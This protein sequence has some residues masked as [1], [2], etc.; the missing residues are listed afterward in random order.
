M[1]SDMKTTQNSVVMG[2]ENDRKEPGRTTPGMSRRGFL[3]KGGA[4]AVSLAPG[5][6]TFAGEVKVSTPSAE[7]LGW[8]AS[9]QHFTYRRFG[10]FEALDKVAA[11][12]LRHIEI[13]SN[14]NLD[15]KRPGLPAHEDMPAEVR[16]ELKARLAERVMSIPSVFA[17]F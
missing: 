2:E 13:R 16:K 5:L 12:G 7:K 8:R 6:S 3:A 15:G 17:D 1:L 14:V 11:P 4:L 9:V 10:L